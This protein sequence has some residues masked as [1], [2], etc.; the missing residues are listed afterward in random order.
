MLAQLQ[1]ECSTVLHLAVT[2]S[3]NLPAL[4]DAM[5]ATAKVN[6][7]GVLLRGACAVTHLDCEPHN[8]IVICWM[9]ENQCRQAQKSQT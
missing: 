5:L 7:H 3:G 2:L 8:L 4:S 1:A 6:A 9:Q